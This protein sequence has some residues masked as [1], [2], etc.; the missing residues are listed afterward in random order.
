MV[1]SIQNKSLK[2]ICCLNDNYLIVLSQKGYFY[3]IDYNNKRII[4][5]VNSIDNAPIK[6]IKILNH[7]EYGQYI[8]LGGFMCGIQIWKN[9]SRIYNHD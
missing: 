3:I 6:I 2:Q 7:K 8:L 4:T 5:K 1:I 9:N